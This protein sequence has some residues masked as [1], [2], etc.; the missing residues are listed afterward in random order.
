MSMIRSPLKLHSLGVSSGLMLLAAGEEI[1]MTFLHLA[2]NETFMSHEDNCKLC[3]VFVF[4]AIYILNI[5]KMMKALYCKQGRS[6]D[7]I[8]ILQPCY[9]NLE[10]TH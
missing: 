8:S 6:S 9:I 1:E 3:L 2:C 4:G 5:Y 10:Q 7:L